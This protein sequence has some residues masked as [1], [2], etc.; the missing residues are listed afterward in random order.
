M[1]LTIKRIVNIQLN[2]QGQIAKNRDFSVIAIVSD[3]WC[4]AYDDVN[5]RFVSI[6]S[7][8]DA[9]LNFGSESRATKAAKAI[10]SVSGV[11]KA[12]VAKWVKENKTTQATANELRGSALNVGINKLKAITSGSFKLN[13]GGADKV[14][15]NLDF[16]SCVDFE[17]VATKLTAAI[18]KD[19]IKAVYDAEGNRFIIRAATAGKNDN[20]R[21]GY[22]EK[23]DSGDFVG[24]LLNLV[25]GKSDIYVG[26]DSVTQKKESLSEALDKLFNATQGF[27]GVYSSAILADEEVAELNEWITSAQ[28]PSVAGYTIT[29]KAQLE[30]EKTN[31]IK[32]I[33]DKDSGRF[34]ATYNNTGD[35]HAGAEL[36]AKALSTNWEGSNTA[37]TMKFKNLKTAGT[38]ETITLNLAEKCDKLGVNYYTDYDGVSM[39]AEGVALG[40][41]FIDET[42]GLDAF[43][44]RTQI[45]VFNV[46]KGAKKVPQTDKGQVR[47]I[48][49]VKQVC[50]QFVKN[51][52]I[53]AGQWRGDPVGTLE[54]GDYLD[55][56]YY[57]YS[58][59]YTEQLQ[60]DRE[61]RKS[62]PINVAIKLAGAIHS[63]DI[64][65]NYNR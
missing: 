43:N 53:A 4:E 26:K 38:D 40:G 2:E 42:V 64:L 19:G 49:A 32:K 58:P 33:A 57:V 29:R 6:A 60:A 35:E 51:G 65:I 15:T 36:L 17:A 9:A 24:V 27:Y 1:S 41:K 52:F 16:S 45:A 23:A 37:Q 50:E 13:V 10:F 48:A 44:N 8:N 55:L 5:T 12:I 22:F 47:L 39:I 54:S 25:S 59:S 61:A 46:L 21:L 34:F 62:V 18:S 31:V 30:S 63:V 56:G 14:Y 7:A 11:K 20:T 28:N 3:D